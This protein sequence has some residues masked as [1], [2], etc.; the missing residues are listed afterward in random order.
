[1]K[2]SRSKFLIIA[3]I[4]LF[5]AY[6]FVFLRVK[7]TRK[8]TGVATGV[9]LEG[10]DMSYWLEDE[11]NVYVGKRAHKFKKRP[12]NA[13]FDQISGE[14]FPEEQGKFVHI[15]NSVS[16]VM[17][18]SKGES[19]ELDVFHIKPEITKELL[20]KINI[21]AGSYITYIGGGLNRATNIR[22]ATKSLDY[23]FIAPGQI[24]SFNR[25]NGPRTIE[26]GYNPAPIIVRGAV[27]PGVG[28]GVCQVST[29]L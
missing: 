5:L 18:A 3:L 19:I 24:F 7:I 13:F 23:Y 27:V 17:E 20:E 11:V 29:T 15:S 1:M 10:R 26:R 6:G 25:A 16:R 14:I 12:R 8:L 9:R 28:G 4:F 22:L 21:E 2:I